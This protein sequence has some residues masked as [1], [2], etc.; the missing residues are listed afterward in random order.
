MFRFVDT[1][2]TG[3][4]KTFGKFTRTCNPGLR[5][6]V[7]IVQTFDIVNNRISQLT[8]CVEIKTK[9]NVFVKLSLAI[10]YQIKPENSESAYFSLDK[11]YSQI[12][13]YVENTVRSQVPKMSLDALFES[14]SDISNQVN[15]FVNIKMNEFGFDIINT[16][17]TDILPTKEVKDAMNKINASL[18]LK[19]A[20]QNEADSLY[21]REI[22][23]AEAERD[24]K[25]LHGEGISQQRCAIVKGYS[26]GVEN[27][28]HSLGLSTKEVSDIVLR[29]QYMDMMEVIGKSDNAKVV[30]IDQNSDNTFKSITRANDVSHEKI[31]ISKPS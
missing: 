6:Y 19:E 1:S 25:R 16:L 30:Y 15:H 23:Q 11:P 29:I 24:R 27:M 12:H 21:I 2:T 5:F 4:V 13:S 22:K 26:E 7:P 8:S 3:I 10:Q 18:R 14:H 17:I 20:A 28:S 9:D 31:D